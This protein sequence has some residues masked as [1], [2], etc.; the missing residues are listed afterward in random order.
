MFQATAASFFATNK[1]YR[2]TV[3]LLTKLLDLW[4]IINIRELSMAQTVT[5]PVRNYMPKTI[6]HAKPE[7]LAERNMRLYEC[8]LDH[9]P[10]TETIAAI[11]E[12]EAMLTGKIP[13]KF[14][15]SFDEFLS[16]LKN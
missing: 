4:Y 2:K 11:E 9:T 13:C 16:D 14:Y 7:T 12:G 8:P 5:I 15:D 1:D 6:N 10:N 3:P